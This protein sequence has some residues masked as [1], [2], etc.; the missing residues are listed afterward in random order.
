MKYSGAI[1]TEGTQVILDRLEVN[2]AFDNEQ[3]SAIQINNE[4]RMFLPSL[5]KIGLKYTFGITGLAVLG[6]TAYSNISG[7]ENIIKD[8]PYFGTGA[9]VLCA[10]IFVIYSIADKYKDSLTYDA[11]KRVLHVEDLTKNFEINGMMKSAHLNPTKPADYIY[12]RMMNRL[13]TINGFVDKGLS[14]TIN[15]Y[16][17]LKEGFSSIKNFSKTISHKALNSITEIKLIKGILGDDNVLEFQKGLSEYFKINE[18]KSHDLK[19]FLKEMA[20]LPENGSL[21]EKVAKLSLSK[22]GSTYKSQLKDILMNKNEEALSETYTID[23]NQKLV[24]KF[25]KIIK[26]AIDSG[27]MDK[28][29][30]KKFADLGRMGV[31]K[32]NAGKIQDDTHVNISKIANY[33]INDTTTFLKEY[34][35]YSFKDIVKKVDN[36]MIHNNKVVIRDFKEI[37][38]SIRDRKLLNTIDSNKNTLKSIILKKLNGSEVKET[39]FHLN[40]KNISN[41]KIW[42]KSRLDLELREKKKS[43]KNKIS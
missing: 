3:A 6:T 35:Q 12:L 41:D 1:L 23:M 29:E 7:K 24:L 20:L 26:E 31:F 36:L 21:A 18:V 33:M 28:H 15:A 43:R 40:E 34:K 19:Q 2:S 27:T 11:R 5:A 39:D 17:I 4:K 10:S 9:L 25:S 30:I 8:L 14:G 32:T 22:N 42:E 37:F 13:M 16:Q 38:F